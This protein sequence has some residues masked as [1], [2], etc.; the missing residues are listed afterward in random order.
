MPALEGRGR[1][2]TPPLRVLLV[3]AGAVGQVYGYHLQKGGAQ[4]AFFVRPKHRAEA[5]GELR[6]Y[7]MRGKHG[8]ELHTWRADEVITD[9]T[10]AATRGFDQIWLCISTA[11]LE[12][13]LESQDELATLLALTAGTTVVSMGPGLHLK[14]LLAPYVPERRRV[15]GG[16]TMVSYQAPLV[17]GE[18][19]APGI[20]AYLPGPSPFTGPEAQ[21]VVDALKRGGAPAKVHS[22]TGALMAFGSATLMPTM[23]AL[24]GAGWKLA[25]MRKGPWARLAAEA[26]AEARAIV[27]AQV[28]ASPPFGTAFVTAPVLKLATWA[29]PKVAPFEVEIY[30][31]Y[32]FTKVRD[33]TERLLTRYVDEGEA[34]GLPH[35]ALSE[36][37]AKVFGA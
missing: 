18:V 24:E 2:Y 9:P 1:T 32:H 12:R 19:D 17:D 31:K 22:N 15:D 34:L 28:H 26:S 36:L 10:L 5:E 21:R 33:Q 8:R 14:Q 13:S 11:A 37:R 29:A 20:A 25:G 4:V 7:Y 35:G 6:L 23:A 30:L 27:A 3:G 16:I